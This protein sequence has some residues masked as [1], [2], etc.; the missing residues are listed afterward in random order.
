M[1]TSSADAQSN[2]LITPPPQPF[3]APP[4]GLFRPEHVEPAIDRGLE[5]ARKN[6]AAIINNPDEP[7]FENTI[8]ALTFADEDLGRAM[9][10]YS[11]LRGAMNTAEVQ[12]LTK[13]IRPKLVRYSLEVALN[14]DLFARIKH[15]YDHADRSRMTAEQKTLLENTY[16]G[17]KNSGALLQG[18]DRAEYERLSQQLSVLTTD[19]SN[20]LINSAAALKVVVKAQDKHRLAGIPA[21]IVES[22]QQNA[23]EDDDPN[24]TADDYVIL[25]AP[26]PVDVLT[27]ADDRS[28]REEVRKVMNKIGAAAPYDNTPLVKDI[29]DLSHKIANLLGFKNHAELTIRPDTRMA[30]NPQTAQAF[31]DKNAQM[32][33]PAARQFHNELEDFARQ[34]DGLAELKSW[35]R[36]YYI[37]L[38]REQ[39]IGFDP[40]EARAYFE[41]ENTLKGMFEHGEKL[42]GIKVREAAG[43]YSRLHED[44]RTYEILDAKTGD[45]KALYFLDPYARKFKN[46]GAWM[47][48][49]RGAGLHDGQ[50]EIPIAGNYCNYNKPAP[51]KPALLTPDEVETLF[52]EFGHACHGMLGKG[53]YPGIN[54]TNTPW[55][56]VELPSQINERWAFK[57]EV[58]AT[59]AKHHETGAPIPQELVDKLQKL[60]RFDMRWQG[61]RQT[62]LGLLDMAYYTTDPADIDD[63]REFEKKVLESTRLSQKPE[64]PNDSSPPSVLTFSHII[65]GGY[66]AGYYSYKWADALVADVFEQFEKQGLYKG[67][68]CKAFREKMIE[69]GGTRPP[70]EMHKDFMEA[71]GQGRRDL[72]QDAMY[73][74]E[75]ILPEAPKPPGL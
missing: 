46:S 66:S 13:I 68:L 54:G 73:R 16:N 34:R 55:D 43:K 1:S 21:D 36:T 39:Q 52:H 20:N 44:V 18:P 10:P 7:T 33:L 59:Y 75:G 57:P 24:I 17:Y 11:E 26:P 12:A 51:G 53:T 38:M 49:I 70:V 27:Y 48:D 23:R 30:Q 3:N 47:S 42:Y 56:Y 58:L 31:L 69:P 63:L 64:D 41:L 40:E 8:H 15:V 22:Y 4:L 28:L 37:R 71:A 35:D 45:V 5:I 62:Q 50:Q 65:G 14:P 29:L 9:G 61:L 2:P 74:A 19:Y 60:G 6:I 32:Y 72:D 25:M 67:D